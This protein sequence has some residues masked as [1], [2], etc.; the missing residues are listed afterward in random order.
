LSVAQPAE[1][2]RNTALDDVRGL[3]ALS[4]ALGHC[5]LV[6]AGLDV[7]GMTLADFPAM[8]VEQMSERLLFLLLPSNAAVMVFFVLSGHVLWASFVRKGMSVPDF[9]DYL[10]A[11]LFR[12]LPLVIASTLLFLLVAVPPVHEIVAN[13]LLISNSMNG[14]LWS[15]QVEMIGSILIFL[16]FL[17]TRDEPLR[18]IA[19]LIVIS[20]LVP[21]FRGNH[22]VVYLPAFVLGAL[23]HHLPARL[24][25]S[26]ALLG[27]ALVFLLL[28]NLVFG[29]RGWA[30]VVEILAAT[31][32]IG[33]IAVQRPAFLEFPML[34][35]LG[36]VSYPFYLVHPL[37]VA[38][39][40]AILGALP[41]LNFLVRFAVYALLSIAIALPIAWVLHVTVEM[42]A[43]RLRPRLSRKRAAASA[44]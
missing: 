9:P 32:I 22:L 36:A 8:T 31:A 25:R 16:V 7:W 37:G 44:P 34:N 3:A 24:L 39:A 43:M 28:P 20:A 33:C 40:I 6:V 30:R 29:Y 4:V 2:F 19:A 38:A 35:F 1:S 26:R 41:E 13:A 12:L 27:I 23:T 42:P 21:L 11:R 10:L 5:L 18:L 17:A 14:V 15:L